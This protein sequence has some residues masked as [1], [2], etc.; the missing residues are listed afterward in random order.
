MHLR[1][2]KESAMRKVGQTFYFFYLVF[3][4]CGV[5]GGAIKGAL[6]LKENDT[7]LSHRIKSDVR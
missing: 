5:S 1:R 6:P 2:S 3:L 7:R 4:G